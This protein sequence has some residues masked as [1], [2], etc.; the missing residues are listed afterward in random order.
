MRSLNLKPI[1]LC[2]DA[3]LCASCQIRYHVARLEANNYHDIV[4]CNI[5][6]VYIALIAIVRERTLKCV[7]Q[8]RDVTQHKQYHA[9]YMKTTNKLL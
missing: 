1:L 7:H 5:L 3:F 9:A 2:F 8:L 4:T 6:Q